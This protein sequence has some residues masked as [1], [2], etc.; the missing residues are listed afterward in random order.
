MNACKTHE[1]IEAILVEI[2]WMSDKRDSCRARASN[3]MDPC[4]DYCAEDADHYDRMLG[5]LG[6]VC[7]S[8]D[9]EKYIE[10]IREAKQKISA[11]GADGNRRA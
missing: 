6:R 5:I 9:R 11:S 1:I 2:K 7:Q 3:P 8:A 10:L 4:A